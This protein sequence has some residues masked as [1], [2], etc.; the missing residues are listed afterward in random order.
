[1]PA[2]QTV[3]LASSQNVFLLRNVN[4]STDS[5]NITAWAI[6]C[7]VHPDAVTAQQKQTNP[8]HEQLDGAWRVQHWTVL[9]TQTSLLSLC[10]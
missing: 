5:E 4:I 3:S 9:H 1:M 7:T 8:A 6:Q 10:C 2:T